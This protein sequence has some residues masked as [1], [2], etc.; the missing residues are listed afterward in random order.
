MAELFSKKITQ[1]GFMVITGAGGGV[2]EAG[3]KGSEMNMS[4]GLN[5]NLPFEQKA[6]PYIA[7][8]PKL[9][10]YK[11]FFDRKLAFV[12]ESDATVLFPGGFGTMDE[13]FEVLT[14]LQNGR[15]AP[16]PVILMSD[17]K[18]R[19]WELWIEFVRSALLKFNY[20]SEEDMN[21][22][23]LSK[24]ADEATELITRFYSRYHS[25]RYV[26]KTSYLRLNSAIPKHSLSRLEQEFSELVLPKTLSLYEPHKCPDDAR[27]YPDKWRLSFRSEKMNFGKL[28]E[29]IQFINTI[30]TPK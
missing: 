10:S 1:K 28:Y 25:V 18:S 11:Y 16:R 12:R 30:E 8:D 9:V 14:L 7:E 13:G 22:F 2:M 19:Y 24:D 21:L 6:N 29:L 17:P 15:C 4:F 27:D 5:I 3:N 23:A 20:I 26:G